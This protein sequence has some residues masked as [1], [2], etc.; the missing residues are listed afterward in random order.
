MKNFLTT[1]FCCF[2]IVFSSCKPEELAPIHDL[3]DNDNVLIFQR[4][5]KG[6][7]IQIVLVAD[8]YQDETISTLYNMY[9]HLFAVEPYPA[10]KDYFT[11]IGI[12]EVDS[13]GITA[14]QDRYRGNKTFISKKI[15]ET[16]KLASLHNTAIVIAVSPE[17]P[18]KRSCCWI[19]ND[20]NEVTLSLC[21]YAGATESYRRYVL[22]HEV[23]GHALGALED[24]YE[25]FAGEI[26][27]S[28]VSANKNW[29]KEGM[30]QNVIFSRDLPSE[31][32]RLQEVFGE[33]V[34]IYEGGG[35][36]QTGAYRS[37]KNSIMRNNPYRYNVVSEYLIWKSVIEHKGGMKTDIEEFI[38]YRQQRASRSFVDEPETAVI[39]DYLHGELIRITE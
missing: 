38:A 21:A 7:G 3:V 34:T 31:W 19:S 2:L 11:V 22:A 39:P 23:G 32:K 27:A 20:H 24:E 6:E 18:F 15:Q 14:Y 25:E 30:L 13:L 1:I 8:G 10:L 16:A 12:K 5:S 35:L 37:S 29:Q 26:P 9:S 4:H 36:Y 28:A 17:L 33:E